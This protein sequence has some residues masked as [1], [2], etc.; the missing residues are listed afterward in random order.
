LVR[1]EHHVIADSKSAGADGS[2]S[3]VGLGTRVDSDL[4]KVVSEARLERGTYCGRQWLRSATQCRDSGPSVGTDGTRRRAGR[5]SVKLVLLLITFRAL[6][7][8]PVSGYLFDP[9]RLWRAAGCR[10]LHD[11]IRYAVGF[12]FAWI[13][14]RTDP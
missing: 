4:A 5:L 9:N 8:D 11:L 6:A 13:V 2:R 1:R 12:N 3:S 10:H 14:R 7:S